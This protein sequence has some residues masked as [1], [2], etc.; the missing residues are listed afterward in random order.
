MNEAMLP[1]LVG[2][3]VTITVHT[4]D[5]GNGSE[6]MILDGC[7]TGALDTWGKLTFQAVNETVYY[8]FCDEVTEVEAGCTLYEAITAVGIPTSNHESDLYFPVS[9]ESTAILACYPSH[10]SN[11]RTF[12]NQVA[13]GH[14]YD[15]PFAFQPWWDARKPKA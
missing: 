12:V 11:A 3:R 14:W 4:R 9:A 15:V 8:L 5:L 1:A 10:K 13:G 6:D 2:R 7:F